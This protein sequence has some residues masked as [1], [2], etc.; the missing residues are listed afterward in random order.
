MSEVA[1]WEWRLEDEETHSHR[2]L[3]QVHGLYVLGQLWAIVGLQEPDEDDGE[4][5]APWQYL[6]AP[7]PEV[8]WIGYEHIDG[9]ET[10]EEAQ[11]SIEKERQQI[12]SITR[13]S[14]ESN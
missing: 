12:L 1:E 3:T 2:G 14:M 4:R 7:D 8:D 6:I 11:A 13:D 9:Y 5:E 10:L